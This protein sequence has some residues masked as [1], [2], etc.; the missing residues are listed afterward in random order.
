MTRTFYSYAIFLTILLMV[1]GV[2]QA[3]LVFVLGPR[4]F[5]LHSMGSWLIFSGL[6]LLTWSLIMSKYYYQKKFQTTFRVFMVATIL[7]LLQTVLVYE[8]FRSRQLSITYLVVTFLLL[9]AGM[10]YSLTLIFSETRKKFWLKCA[11]FCFLIAEMLLTV[12]LIA[13]LT[14]LSYRITWSRHAELWLTLLMSAGTMLLTMNFFAERKQVPKG[15]TIRQKSI[16]EVIGYVVMASIVATVIFVP[17]LSLQTIELKANPNNVSEYLRKLAQPFKADFYANASGDTLRYRLLF[18]VD[19]DSTKLY[20]VVVCL[21]GSSGCGTDNIKQVGA[22]TPTPF[23]AQDSNRRKHPAFLFVPQCPPDFTWGGVPETK[24]VDALV[25][26]TLTTL[27][28]NFS[29]DTTRRYVTGNSLGGYGTWHFI[30][31]HPEK[32]AAAVPLCGSGDPAFAEK[33]I[34]VPVWAFHGAKDLIVPASGSRNMIEAMRAAGGTPRYSEFVD[35][36]HDISK[37]VMETPG[38]LT[39]LFAQKK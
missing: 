30:S 15:D 19:Y 2:F 8:F 17:R 27:E 23:L 39:W 32:F 22:A 37:N 11:G 20:P 29:I 21:H 34:D 24:A 7:S 25:F 10:V 18:P 28:K 6:L 31:T 5:E 33:L 1:T 13:N 26:E 12:S 4:T 35:A 14:S 9:I 36:G 16:D 38:L 3:T